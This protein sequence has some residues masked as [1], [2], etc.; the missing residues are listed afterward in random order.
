MYR[1]FITRASAGDSDNTDVINQILKLRKEK[2]AIL[3]YEHHAAVS[4][5]SK[6]WALRDF[7]PGIVSAALHIVH[8][9]HRGTMANCTLLTVHCGANAHAFADGRPACS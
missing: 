1:A 5:A 8:A 2:A 7:F 4:M 3:G 9:T 6:V